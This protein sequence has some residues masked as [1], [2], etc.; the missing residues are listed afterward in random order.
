METGGM[1]PRLI[2]IVGAGLLMALTYGDPLQR[3]GLGVVLHPEV[4]IQLQTNVW[5]HVIMIPLPKP[6]PQNPDID[7]CQIRQNGTRAAVDPDPEAQNQEANQLIEELCT[8]YEAVRKLGSAMNSS[9]SQDISRELE[10]L[11]AILMDAASA[12][13]AAED[14]KV[15][16]R[17][18]AP[19][20]KVPYSYSYA[21]IG[22]EPFTQILRRVS[23]LTGRY[24]ERVKR[25]LHILLTVWSHLTLSGKMNYLLNVVTELAKADGEMLR[26]VS[27]EVGSVLNLLQRETKLSKERHA[28]LRKTLLFL[29]EQAQKLQHEVTH[30]NWVMA[31]W[32]AYTEYAMVAHIQTYQMLQQYLMHIM[33]VSQG[34][35]ALTRG[36]LSP[37]LLSVRDLNRTMVEVKAGLLEALPEYH[38][39]VARMED[40][41]HLPLEG[42]SVYTDILFITLAIPIAKTADRF[43][44]YR[45]QT[46]PVPAGDNVTNRFTRIVSTPDY[47]G[48][49]GRYFVELSHPEYTQCV[50]DLAMR[51]CFTRFVEHH[52]SQQTCALALYQND[53]GAVARKCAA[54]FIIVDEPRDLIIPLSDSR[55]YVVA[56]GDPSGWTISCAGRRPGTID[57][58]VACEVELPCQC[59]LRTAHSYIPAPLVGCSAGQ[60]RQILD[61]P[62][63]IKNLLY[64]F[65]IAGGSLR[66]LWHD[67]R[68]HN[69]T[70]ALGPSFQV[71]T[72]LLR[73]GDENM[74]AQDRLEVDM[75]QLAVDIEDERLTWQNRRAEVKKKIADWARTA[76]STTKQV[77]IAILI[78]IIIVVIL[79][80]G[81]CLLTGK[82]KSLATSYGLLTAMPKVGG[83]YEECPIACEHITDHLPAVIELTFMLAAAICLIILIVKQVAKLYVRRHAVYRPSILFPWSSQG[84]RQTKVLLEVGNVKEFAIFDLQT[85][86]G[87]PLRY[88]LRNPASTQISMPKLR[89][90]LGFWRHY[91]HIDWKAV[92]LVDEG[93][94]LPVDLE[95][96][97]PVPFTLR[98]MTKRILSQ[99]LALRLL[100]GSMGVYDSM[101][102][103]ALEEQEPLSWTGTQS[104][105]T[106]LIN[107]PSLSESS[108]TYR[109][110]QEHL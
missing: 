106:P 88:S 58:C 84:S 102:V 110:S 19:R 36:R 37:Q 44:V 89:Y 103:A 75:K 12:Y 21:E 74:E 14:K 68:T 66:T 42:V 50:G 5:R 56:L 79:V 60:S 3:L 8:G 101:P 41:Y 47:I 17:R 29:M 108:R 95:R 33:R 86:V 80:I 13:E 45:I 18:Q 54:H 59:S 92:K 27:K 22:E 64:L 20:E 51:T 38:V 26:H 67:I 28:Q 99:P 77:G 63:Y 98:S 71:D 97:V 96:S 46:F 23:V 9:L 30:N 94:E 16:E 69:K 4:P 65:K 15:R 43:D 6:L 49:Y 90:Q 39:G 61:Q 40:L 83:S 7:P 81:V 32:R 93:Q 1:P 52:F 57:S 2:L 48:I 62:V 31:K 87:S 24:R 73:E 107:S 25:F 53:V 72:L 85:L 76:H 105:R 100:V 78:V 104:R 91:I 34:V 10:T 35:H 82:Y 109:R 70:E 11:E 55:M